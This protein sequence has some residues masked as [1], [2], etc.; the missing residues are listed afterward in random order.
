MGANGDIRQFYFYDEYLWSPTDFANLQTW[1][2]DNAKA[3][4]VGA[5]GPACLQGLRVSPGGGMNVDVTAGI[6]VNED[7]R[8]LIAGGA[9][10]K[11]FATPSGNPAWSLLVLRPL[12]VDF[13][14]INE[15]T[16]PTNQV[17]LHKK[18]QYQWVVLNGTPAASPSYPALTAGDVAVMGFKLANGQTTINASDFDYSARNVSRKR[19][20]PVKEVS[21]TY[22][23]LATDQV[24]EHDASSASGLSLLPTAAEA[25]QQEFTIVKTD[26]SANVVAVSGQGSDLIS[27][28]PSSVIEDQWGFVKVYSNGKAWRMV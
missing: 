26:S 24:I 15:P 1:L 21:G 9:T 6:A 27:G 25:A 2:Q 19:Q 3:M 5:H 13:N 16:N 8:P 17:P 10:G 11:T 4:A 7:G 12:D 18:L 20:M 22:M 23:V 28:Q 14:N